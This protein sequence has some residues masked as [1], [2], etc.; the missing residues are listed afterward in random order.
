MIDM[1][2]KENLKVRKTNFLEQSVLWEMSITEKQFA[3]SRNEVEKLKKTQPPTCSQLTWR[4]QGSI[5][6]TLLLRLNVE[7]QAEA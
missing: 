1:K 3:K 4:K 2:S 6:F 7:L 5:Q